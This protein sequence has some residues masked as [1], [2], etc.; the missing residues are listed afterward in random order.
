MLLP[1]LKWYHGF[2]TLLSAC[3]KTPRGYLQKKNK[4][5]NQKSTLNS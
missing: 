3:F 2:A 4:A 5:I 1:D